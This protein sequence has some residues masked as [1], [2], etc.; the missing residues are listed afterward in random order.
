MLSTSIGAYFPLVGAYFQ[1]VGAYFPLVGAYTSRCLF[2]TSI[3][4]YFPLV[5]AYFQLVG[6]YFPLVGAYF[7]LVGSCLLEQRA[8][9]THAVMHDLLLPTSLNDW[10]A[11]GESIN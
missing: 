1:L 10:R 8:S 11:S 2:S 6:A 3:G 4:A 5:G 9:V 7:Q